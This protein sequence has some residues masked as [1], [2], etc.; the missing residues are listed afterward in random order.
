MSEHETPTSPTEPTTPTSP[1]ATD[2]EFVWDAWPTLFE[3]VLGT[4]EVGLQEIGPGQAD[5]LDVPARATL[6]VVHDPAGNDTGEEFDTFSKADR[7]VAWLRRHLRRNIRLVVG[8]TVSEAELAETHSPDYLDEIRSAEPGSRT[9]SGMAWDERF[10]AAVVAS[11][12]SVRTAALAAWTGRTV[13]GATSSGLHH[14]RYDHGAGFCTLNGLVVAARAVL[15]AGAL[16]VLVVDLDA[17]AGGGTASLIEDVAGIEQVDV[18]VVGYDTYE[19]RPDARLEVVG[20]DDYLATVEQVLGGVEDPGSV[21][22][23]IYNA[24][25]DP[26]ECAG[27]VAGITTRVLR[28]RDRMVMEWAE[29]HDLPVAFVMAGGYQGAT[30]D[31]DDVAALHGVTFEEALRSLE[32]RAG[33]TVR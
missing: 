25:M 31:L 15:A 12:S 8:E 18:T 23:V 13:V 4:Q 10:W 30:W 5:G 11:T 26:H 32:R 16:R 14:A 3:H 17:H 6:T 7:I 21:D 1:G 22:L 27:G 2:D 28:R 19:S 33:S 29:A 9:S 24:G 20:A